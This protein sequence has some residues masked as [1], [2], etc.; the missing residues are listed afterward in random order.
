M[1]NL[2]RLYYD[3][4]S[5]RKRWHVR[6]KGKSQVVE[7]GRLGGSLRESKKSFKTPA[8]ATKATEKLIA[9]KKREGY[10]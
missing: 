3:D 10:F 1:S 7:Y 8:E 4:G 2:T 5:S 9:K 6:T